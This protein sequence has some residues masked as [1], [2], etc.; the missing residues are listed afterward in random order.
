MCELEFFEVHHWTTGL[1]KTNNYDDGK[2]DKT[3]FGMGF[4]IR[5]GF[6]ESNKTS[7]IA[8]GSGTNGQP[9][10][11]SQLIYVV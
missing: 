3:H 8:A 7:A 9:Q 6:P 1:Q 10:T 2:L 4:G 5:R 11:T